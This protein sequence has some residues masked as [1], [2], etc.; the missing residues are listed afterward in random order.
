MLELSHGKKNFDHNLRIFD[1]I[2]IVTD[3]RPNGQTYTFRQQITRLC[4]TSRE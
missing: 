3:R 2:A 4:I 1:T